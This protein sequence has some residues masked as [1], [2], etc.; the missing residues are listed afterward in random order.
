MVLAMSVTASQA[1]A[2]AALERASPPVGGAVTEPPRQ[3][4]L[5]FT[6]GVEPLFSTVELRNAQGSAISTGTPHLAGNNRQLVVDLPA[7][8]AGE[9]KVIWHATSVDTH[10]TEGSFRFTIR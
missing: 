6:E 2:H 4:A 1:H 9:Y 5:T 10:K 8:P 7:L 3:I